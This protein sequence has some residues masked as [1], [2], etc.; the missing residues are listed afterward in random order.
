MYETKS[1]G[2]GPLNVRQAYVD[3]D[4]DEV[5]YSCAFGG[6]GVGGPLG[7]GPLG[8]SSA[9]D[10]ED[11]KKTPIVLTPDDGT[12]T[13]E[14]EA[15]SDDDPASP[16]SSTPSGG[17]AG[18]K[19]RRGGKRDLDDSSA[20][21]R[22]R[23][24]DLLRTFADP[25]SAHRDGPQLLCAAGKRGIVKIVDTVRR[26][27][28]L[29]LSGH[30]DEINDMKFG[31]AD[32]WLL[33]TAS[34]DCS[35]RLWN[36]RTA[37]CVG[38]FAGHEAHRDT[39]LTVGWHPSGD[40]FASAGVD[41]TVKLWSLGEGTEVCD[42]L[43]KSRLVR[44]KNRGGLG[45]EEDASTLS[46]L[47]PSKKR[48][49]EEHDDDDAG[50]GGGPPR[51]GAFRTVYEQMPY[52]SSNQIHTDYVD[53]VQFVGDLVLSKST[54]DRI[55]LWKPDLSPPSHD[56]KSTEQTHHRLPNR[57]VAL[58]EFS[59]THCDV[60]FIRF[61]TDLDCQMLAIGNTR[62]DVK[63]WEIAG[64]AVS[65]TK[66]HFANLT[67]NQCASTVRMVSFSPDTRSLVA[68]CDDSTLWKWDAI[69]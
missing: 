17:A 28:V 44:P 51:D 41:T 64:S 62:G 49:T 55:V 35:I 7:Y 9:A 38:I 12:T 24:D 40:R 30:G 67:N 22:R 47:P 66:K 45:A 48:A 19:R 65:P 50:E 54:A 57:V 10:A 15:S 61:Q 13:E 52:F 6:R 34:N 36:V 68:T 14:E 33:L 58:R 25:S 59:L 3:V 21:R 11:G 53:C 23:D 39:V 69:W 27:L 8:S 5:Y 42:A 63:V 29:T 37:T 43:K 1:S 20:A 2:G 56:D 4:P 60:W 26:S 32:D 46:S 31:P 16:S 18:E